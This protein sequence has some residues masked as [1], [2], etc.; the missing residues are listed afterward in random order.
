[1]K[2]LKCKNILFQSTQPHRNHGWQARRWPEL[3][4]RLLGRLMQPTQFLPSSTQ[5]SSIP[6]Q[7]EQQ[8]QHEP[9]LV[10]AVQGLAKPEYRGQLQPLHRFGEDSWFVSSTPAADVLGVA[11]GVG[12]WK[13]MGVDAGLFAKELM[14]WCASNA[15]L[16]Q[17]DARKPR[18]L[19][20]Q[21]YVQLCQQAR[22]VPGS[23]TAC[24]LSLHRRDCALYTANLGDSG[25][26]V[27]RY[28]KILHRSVE[29]LHT[30]NT[31]YQLTLAPDGQ[32]ATVHCDLPQM[33][34][35]TRLPLQQGD[36]VLLATDGLFDNVPESMLVRMMADYQG[37]TDSGRL[38][39]GA[40]M[41]VSM[42]RD[43]SQSAYFQSPFA[44][45]ARANNMMYMGGGKPDDITVILASVAV[46][47][48]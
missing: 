12:S 24:L 13:Q 45:K 26:L 31:P 2:Y 1:M 11:D 7:Q 20:I 27:M 37:V 15:A 33:A 42:A 38:Q 4:R 36:L 29:Q 40:N 35:C 22:P 10:N 23:S 41:L 39:L 3:L 44:Q 21:S 14:Y 25:F 47:K 16:P 32:R 6:Q 5:N 28:G 43:L 46:R 17:F 34:A 18:D 48:G 30:F 8:Q 9:Y 19:L